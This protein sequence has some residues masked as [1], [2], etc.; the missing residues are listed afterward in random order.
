MQIKRA[1]VSTCIIFCLLLTACNLPTVKAD[2]T[3]G[4][5]NFT[6]YI[7]DCLTTDGNPPAPIQPLL[8]CDRWQDNRYE[9]PFNAG[10]QDTYYS[11]MDILFSALGRSGGWFFARVTLNALVPDA[12]TLKGSYGIEIDTD[13]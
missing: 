12:Q 2:L 4:K 5:S 10:K 9:R 11:D 1:I 6:N 3:P 7:M 8:N 13:R